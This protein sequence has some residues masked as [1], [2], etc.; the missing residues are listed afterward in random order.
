MDFRI[1]RKRYPS[2]VYSSIKRSATHKT[3]NLPINFKCMIDYVTSCLNLYVSGTFGVRVTGSDDSL[4]VI[5]EVR[6]FI[7]ELVNSAGYS[8]ANW[9]VQ[10][11]LVDG[12]LGISKTAV[13]Q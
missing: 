12:S 2:L 4:N 13:H 11:E 6:M 5:L 7:E 9:F 8:L 10:R 1:T 3:M